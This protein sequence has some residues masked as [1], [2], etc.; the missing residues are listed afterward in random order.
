MKTFNH[1][2]G[3]HVSLNGIELYYEELGEFDK[4]VI[5]ML[6]GGFQNIENL[7]II[8]PYLVDNYRVIGIDTRG[9]GKS[10]IGKSNLT[11]LQIESDIERLLTILKID[12]INIIGFSD[13]GIVGYRLAANKN[14]KVDKLVTIGASWCNSDIDMIEGLIKQITPESAKSMFA[15]NYNNYLRTNPE[16][17]FDKLNNSIVSLWLDKTS[18]GHPNQLVEQI[19]AKTLLIRGDNDFLVSAESLIKLQEKIEEATFCN[20]PFAEHEVHIEQSE[21]VKS[22]ITQFLQKIK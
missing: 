1:N 3:K 14:I 21:V 13:G 11:Y 19:K 2:R 18:D 20:I 8:T 22:I 9:H 7:N 10:T 4:P 17:D 12:N 6:H 16:P 15:D 5:L